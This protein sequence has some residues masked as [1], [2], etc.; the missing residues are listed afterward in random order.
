MYFARLGQE[1]GSFELDKCNKIEL[2]DW[3][4]D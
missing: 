1:Q 2:I 4:R 3:S